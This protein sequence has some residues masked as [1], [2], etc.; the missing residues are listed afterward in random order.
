MQVRVSVSSMSPIGKSMHRA[1][2]ASVHWNGGTGAWSFFNASAPTT[3][4]IANTKA[5]T[6][7]SREQSAELSSAQTK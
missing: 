7:R 6:A 3:M 4:L 2:R 1:I 5:K